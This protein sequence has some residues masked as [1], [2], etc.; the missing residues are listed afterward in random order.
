MKF[1]IKEIQYASNTQRTA[2]IKARDDVEAVLVKNGYKMLVIDKNIDKSSLGLS[3]LSFHK[4]TLNAWKDIFKE[5]GIKSGDEVVVQ[6]PAINH[7]LFLA[8]F[9]KSCVKNNIKITLLIHDMEILRAA[10]RET[11]KFTRK[12]RI[13]LEEKRMLKIADRIIVHNEKMKNKLLEMGFSA[14]KLVNLEIFDYLIDDNGME[15]KN[16]SCTKND[17]VIIAGALRRHKVGY[18]YEL[19]ENIQFNLYGVGYEEQEQDNINYLGSFPSDDLPF[20]LVGSFGLVWDGITSKTCA[21]TFGEYLRINNPHKTSLYLASGIPVIIWKEAALA[22]FIEKNK[23]GIT[24][25][26]LHEIAD[27][28]N[29]MTDEEYKEIKNNTLKIAP[30][31]REGFYVKKA[32]E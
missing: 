11:T 32:V 16:S 2:G 4:A 10:A 14:D 30:K 22:E 15:Y 8:N 20:E 26:S 24:V 7:S 29:L 23:C 31:L 18:V 6:F 19:P 17:P 1:I 13:N 27:R 3:S 12:I 5:G 28:I 9:F 25:N 21:G